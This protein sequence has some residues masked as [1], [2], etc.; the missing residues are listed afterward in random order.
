MNFFKKSE[1]TKDIKYFIKILKE[2]KK[3]GEITNENIN[4]FLKIL[5]IYQEKKKYFIEILKKK[6]E[7]GEIT[8]ENI[9]DFLKILNIL[10]IYQEKK[11]YKEIFDINIF[12]TWIEKVKENIRKINNIKNNIQDIENYPVLAYQQKTIIAVISDKKDDINLYNI[13]D[14]KVDLNNKEY[15]HFHSGGLWFSNNIENYDKLKEINN[16]TEEDIYFIFSYNY[17]KKYSKKICNKIF[18]SLKKTY[19]NNYKLLVLKDKKAY[20]VVIMTAKYVKENL[21]DGEYYTD[22]G[23]L[24]DYLSK[25]KILDNKLYFTILRV[26]FENNILTIPLGTLKNKINKLQ[27]END[28]YFTDEMVE[29]I[30][31]K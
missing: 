27:I 18:N 8:N 4:G 16:I 9:N 23:E 11:K 29:E 2:K 28:Y 21:G 24:D 12:K 26:T 3:S 30:S 19:G 25:R 17:G 31:Y 14:N 10:K 13:A 20:P 5:K 1:D 6:H 15:P 22:V 7:Y